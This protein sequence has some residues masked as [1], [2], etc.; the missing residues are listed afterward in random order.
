MKKI[1]KFTLVFLFSC[2]NCFNLNASAADASSSRLYAD[3]T[4][5]EK[6]LWEDGKTFEQKKLDLKKL[7]IEILERNDYFF[8]GNNHQKGGMEQLTSIIA[9]LTILRSLKGKSIQQTV[10]GRL[11]NKTIDSFLKAVILNRGDELSSKQ[12]LTL[13]QFFEDIHR[14]FAPDSKLVY[15]ALEP[16][17]DPTYETTNPLRVLGHKIYFGW[18]VSGEY[19]GKAYHTIL[20]EIEPGYK[21]LFHSNEADIE[22][23][24]AKRNNDGLV[25]I[26]WF[27]F[28]VLLCKIEEGFRRNIAGLKK[29]IK[30]LLNDHLKEYKVVM[31]TPSEMEDEWGILDGTWCDKLDGRS[32]KFTE[33]EVTLFRKVYS[34]VLR[35]K[36]IELKQDH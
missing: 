24:M 22:R 13:E 20:L 25:A 17:T 3:V 10:L 31:I 1:G 34:R 12:E 30:T 26:D 36:N 28:V 6:I 2:I 11:M 18:L 8:E 7:A 15:K 27:R 19:S 32:R 14:D 16:I 35:L 33:I 5:A 23:K 9:T 4:K 21:E 29:Q